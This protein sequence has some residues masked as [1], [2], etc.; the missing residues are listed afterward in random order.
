MAIVWTPDKID[1][2]RRLS[3]LSLA[4]SEIATILGCP[5]KAVSG[6][7]TRLGITRPGMSYAQRARRLRAKLLAKCQ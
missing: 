2:L 3:K 1:E 5:G 6:K 7:L 4:T